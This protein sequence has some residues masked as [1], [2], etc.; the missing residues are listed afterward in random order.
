[1]M[2]YIIE[3]IKHT[4]VGEV[5]LLLTNA[6][7]TNPAY[8]I[9]FTNKS[10]QREG[11]L[12]LFKASLLINNQ[13]QTLTKIIKEKESG[14]IIGTFTLIPPQGVKGSIS[15][16]TKIELWQFMLR[17]GL[18]TLTRM[19]SLDS[20]NKSLLAD[21]LKHAPHYYLSMVVIK[22]EYRGKGVGSFALQ[23]AINELIETHP[24]CRIIGLT[25]QLP[26]N[27]TFYSRL[28]FNQLD[29]GYITF[30]ESKYYNYNMTLDLNKYMTSMKP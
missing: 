2:D 23:Q 3:P 8:S 19:L 21:S 9:V 10:R 24:V 5:A 18:N 26:E 17:F 7:E 4:Q 6:F 30:K 28:G 14:E 22:E 13:N 12:W 11:L 16:Y 29:E 1:M 27:V 20:L 25:T 15:I